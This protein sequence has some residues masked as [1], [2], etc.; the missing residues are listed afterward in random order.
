MNARPSRTNHARGQVRR[1]RCILA[2]ALLAGLVFVSCASAMTSHAGW[3]PN[4]HLVMDKGPAGRTNTLVGRQGV[5]N[6]L[7]G[8]TEVRG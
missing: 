4:Q 8:G 3:P 2:V 6:Y 7:L 5:H 1:S